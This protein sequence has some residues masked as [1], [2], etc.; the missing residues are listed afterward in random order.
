MNETPVSKDEIFKEL[1][2]Y[3][4]M[5]CCYSDGRILGSM[6]TEAHPIAKEAFYKF[7]YSNLGDRGLFK[8]TKLIEDEVLKLIGSFLSIENP[9]G[10][11][12]TGGTEA[13]LMAMRAARNIARDKYG[14]ENGEIIVPKSAHFSLNKASDML[15]LKLVN[16]D[17]ND[18]FGSIHIGRVCGFFEKNRYFKLPHEAAVTI[19]QLA[20]YK[21]KLPQG[22]PTSP[23]ITN[24]ICQV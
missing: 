17:L 7:S 4:A 6:C 5:D 16:V 11:I 23:I 22:A 14:I 8:G 9:V 12:V 1:D 18:F 15:N 19:A 2:E 3:Q 24:L 20:C 13:N 21:G 10:H